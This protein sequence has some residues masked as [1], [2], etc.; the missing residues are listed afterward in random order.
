MILC[1]VYTAS[2]KAVQLQ[3]MVHCVR[4]IIHVGYKRATPSHYKELGIPQRCLTFAHALALDPNGVSVVNN[5]II[6]PMSYRC[7]LT[8]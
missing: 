2:K 1:R 3:I 6:T 7:V 8:V 5:T 4:K